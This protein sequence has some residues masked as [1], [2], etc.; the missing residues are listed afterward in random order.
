[1]HSELDAELTQ[2][3]HFPELFSHSIL[4]Q[5]SRVVQTQRE[6]E[7]ERERFLSTWCWVCW[8]CIRSVLDGCLLLCAIAMHIIQFVAATAMG[9]RQCFF[10]FSF[11]HILRLHA[12]SCCFSVAFA[13]QAAA[14][15]EEE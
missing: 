13:Q 9:T 11:A 3:F 2:F 8:V 14:A 15:E 6:R 5:I 4:Q 7:R 12:F 1:M 10:F